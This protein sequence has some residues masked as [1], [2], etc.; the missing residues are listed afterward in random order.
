M[1]YA[2]AIGFN[3]EGEFQLREAA[4]RL[5]G[6]ESRS[7]RAQRVR[8]ARTRTYPAY[9]SRL[10]RRFD[11][12]DTTAPTLESVRHGLD[13]AN[14]ECSQGFGQRG[15]GHCRCFQGDS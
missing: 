2:N 8:A 14:H 5:M 10:H 12:E 13:R 4:F 7:R 15:T 11:P 1:D 6:F 3:K 9:V